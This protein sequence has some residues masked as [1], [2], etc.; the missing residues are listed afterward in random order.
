MTK[1]EKYVRRRL[2]LWEADFYCA[3]QQLLNTPAALQKT[4]LQHN[5][6]IFFFFFACILTVYKFLSHLFCDTRWKMEHEKFQRNEL[7]FLLDTETFNYT[8][9]Y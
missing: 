7:A 6:I 3:T 1:D 8:T 4:L 2:T 5:I 9:R